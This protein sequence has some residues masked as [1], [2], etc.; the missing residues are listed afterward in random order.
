MLAD[1]IRPAEGNAS[2]VSRLREP[3]VNAGRDNL[4]RCGGEMIEPIPGLADDVIGFEAK[5]EVTKDDYVQRLIPAVDAALEKHDK[6]RL[7]YVLGSDF[8]GYSGSAMWQDTKLGMEH[9]TKWERVAV[10]S[11]HAWIRHAVNVLGYLIPGEVKAFELAERS[12][13]AAWVSS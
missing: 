13:A 5:G 3:P 10:V 6:V 8:T 1:G 7:I 2:S 9:L 11:D 4:D 12:D